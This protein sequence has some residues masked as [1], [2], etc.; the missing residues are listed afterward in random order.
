MFHVPL[1]LT[2]FDPTAGQILMPNSSKDGHLR[3]RSGLEPS[4]RAPKSAF[5]VIF[6]AQE[7]KPIVLGLGNKLYRYFAL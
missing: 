4:Y 6:L 2:F 7:S 1:N 5:F 3:S